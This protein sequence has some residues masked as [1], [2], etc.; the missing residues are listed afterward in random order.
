M[1]DIF[2]YHNLG[3]IGAN[4]SGHHFEILYPKKKAT[5]VSKSEYMKK[6]KKTI[7]SKKK[8]RTEKRSIKRRGV[9]QTVKKRRT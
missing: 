3:D 1:K 5:I 9:K 2:L 8:K 6:V 4:N 7:L